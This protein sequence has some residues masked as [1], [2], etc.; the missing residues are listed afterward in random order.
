MQTNCYVVDYENHAIIIDPCCYFD[1]EKQELD[2][3]ITSNNLKVDRI[4]VTHMHVDHILGLNWCQKKYGVVA[5]GPTNENHL[6]ETGKQLAKQF[7]YNIDDD[8]SPITKPFEGGAWVNSLSLKSIHTPGHS[9]GHLCYLIEDYNH[10]LHDNDVLFCGDVIFKDGIGRYDFPDSN[11][12]DL[13]KSIEL[14]K[15]QPVL[16]IYPGHGE[17]FSYNNERSIP[18]ISDLS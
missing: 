4:L 8:I 7:G 1:N 14:V 13:Q 11:Y 5:E 15:S 3:Y 16:K 2:D 17:S 18:A 6:I 10:S 12:E 9:P